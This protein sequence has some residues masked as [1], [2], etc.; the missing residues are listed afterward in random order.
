MR[1]YYKFVS[2]TVFDLENSKITQRVIRCMRGVQLDVQSRYKRVT[3]VVVLK[4]ERP[5]ITYIN[6]HNDTVTQ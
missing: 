1:T 3:C 5:L 6:I 2:H 4:D